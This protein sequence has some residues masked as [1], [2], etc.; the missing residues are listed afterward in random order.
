MLSDLFASRQDFY[1]VVNMVAVR[2]VTSGYRFSLALGT[3]SCL[4]TLLINLAATIY[5]GTK[6][7]LD[8]DGRGRRVLYTGSCDTS[9][10]LN[11]VLHVLINILSSILL[12]ASNYG[13]QCLS[14]PTR[15]QVDK[16]HAKGTYLDIGIV[17]VRN[18][19]H[20][21]HLTRLLWVSLVLSSIPLHL[22]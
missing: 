7:D 18:L 20:Q 21:T 19:R 2:K 1:A 4:F 14:A 13:I 22:L 17:S 9:K 12:G 16:A 15:E 10:N 5:A 11:T 6:P 3:V 8:N